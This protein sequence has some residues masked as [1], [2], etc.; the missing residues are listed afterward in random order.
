M[1]R[2]A[3]CRC[4]APLIGRL[5]IAALIRLSTSSS[6]VSDTGSFAIAGAVEALPVAI[7][8][9]LPCP[10]RVAWW[11]GSVRR[12]V[13]LPVAAANPLGPRRSR[14]A[15]A[16][17]GRGSGAPRPAIGAS[18]GPRSRRSRPAC[19][20][21]GRTLVPDPELRQCAFALDAV[22]LEVCFIV[23]PSVTAALV[24]IGSPAAAVLA[25]AASRRRHARFRRLACLALLAREPERRGIGPDRCEPAGSV[26]LLF[27]EFGFGVAIGAMEISATAFATQEG[28]PGLAGAL[29][30]VQ[31]AASMAG[32]LWYGSA[33]TRLGR[34]SAIHASACCRA[35]IRAAAADDA[36]WPAR[37][38]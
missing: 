15:A 37:C 7:A 31:A 13:L 11:I 12:A 24:A 18:A 9:A 10:C 35:R 21:C 27:V 28:S 20:P 1:R 17:A 34:Q 19:G 3:G 26:V 14:L 2:R 29:I 25:N 4:S 30:A 38:R 8:V 22:L 16:K 33:G 5:P 6:S 23:G 36:R 32:G